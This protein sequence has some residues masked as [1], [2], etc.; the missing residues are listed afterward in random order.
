MHVAVKDI[1]GKT[2]GLVAPRARSDRG[3][4]RS[5][6]GQVLHTFRSCVRENRKHLG[7]PNR[8]AFCK[9][10]WESGRGDT[11]IALSGSQAT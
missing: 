4:Q 6:L 1:L 11:G 2:K 9:V 7:V 5:K 10:G 8:V 3:M